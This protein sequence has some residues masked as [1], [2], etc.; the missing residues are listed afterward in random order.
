MPAEPVTAE[1]T[2]ADQGALEGELLA[3]AAGVAEGRFEPTARPHRGLC[4]DCPGR[5]ALCSWGEEHTL[6]EPAQAG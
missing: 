3:L 1:Y 2:A 4:A 5:P 6:A